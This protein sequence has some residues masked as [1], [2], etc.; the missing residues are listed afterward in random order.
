MTTKNKTNSVES[1]AQKTFK[2]RLVAA[3]KAADKAADSAFQA[4][5]KVAEVLN[6]QRKPGVEWAL[7]YKRLFDMAKKTVETAKIELKQERNLWLYVGQHLQIL[8]N[9]DM[10]IEIKTNKGA[11]LVEAGDLK[12][13]RDV[14]QAAKQIR[15]ATGLAD[16]RANNSRGTKKTNAPEPVKKAAEVKAVDN[17]SLNMDNLKKALHSLLLVSG[18][19]DT[20]AGILKAEGYQL[21]RIVLAEQLE[22]PAT[23]PVIKTAGKP[24]P[25]TKD[26]KPT[27]G[28]INL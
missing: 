27:I 18:G 12:T 28:N 11:K 20:L 16:G 15:E 4:C 5:R 6:E 14:A 21:S 23:K 22:Q 10:P 3:V 7:E 26:K 17:L 2:I 9:G 13:A 1:T 8:A 25:A 24:K 19:F